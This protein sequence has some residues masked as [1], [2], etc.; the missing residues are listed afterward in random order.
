MANI[1][2]YNIA[3][4]FIDK[5]KKEKPLYFF[6]HNTSLCLI[7]TNTQ[8]IFS[9]T[10][11]VKINN[12]NIE[13]VCSDYNAVLDF[14]INGKAKAEQM[15]VVLAENYSII[16][17]SLESIQMLI[18]ADSEN[19]NCEIILSETETKAASNLYAS[20]SDTN[21]S[22]DFFSGFDD[23][24]AEENKTA[25][26][27]FS[28]GFDFG[29]NGTP[30]PEVP[31][32]PNHNN[33]FNNQ[34]QGRYQSNPSY[35]QPATSNQSPPIATG[36]SKYLNNGSVYMQGGS[37]YMQGSQYASQYIGSAGGGSAF[38]KRLESFLEDDE[39]DEKEEKIEETSENHEMSLQERLKQAKKNK[40][41]A[42]H[43][44]KF[45]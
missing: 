41:A 21:N 10:T 1:E 27:E 43:G 15:V 14:I 6:E 45:P 40:K 33:G 13:T 30:V 29:G 20:F 5:I 22:T 36:G 4:I 17:P 18:K 16:T 7:K 38:R 44:F 39:S 8:A 26:S 32:L 19:A 3:K 12:G 31:V 35:Q 24:P 9:G 28:D 42:K 11:C 2:L 23:V 25:S 37:Q 34:Q